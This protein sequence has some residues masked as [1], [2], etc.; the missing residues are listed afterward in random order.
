MA[1]AS[2]PRASRPATPR[3]AS[4]IASSSSVIA[5]VAMR[6]CTSARPP[7]CLYSEGARTFSRSASWPSVR[8]W[9]PTSSTITAPAHVMSTALRPALGIGLVELSSE[10]N[11]R[12]G[13]LLR[14]VDVRVV[15][16]A[17]DQHEIGVE[18]PGDPLRLGYRIG[19]VDVGGAHDHG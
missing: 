13:Y 18:P 5:R 7:T 6:C 3:M 16:R 9:K 14:P 8:L 19:P 17:V 15:A 1:V 2:A 12:V 11:D 10:G 4:R